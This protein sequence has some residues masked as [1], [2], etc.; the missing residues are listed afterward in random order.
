MGRG[1]WVLWGVRWK[2]INLN[3]KNEY[4]LILKRTMVWG[5]IY[6]LARLKASYCWASYTRRLLWDQICADLLKLFGIPVTLM[7]TE[8][9][10]SQC[11]PRHSPI[12]VEWHIV[13]TTYCLSILIQIVSTMYQNI[14]FDNYH[15]C[16]NG[17]LSL[18]IFRLLVGQNDWPRSIFARVINYGDIIH[19]P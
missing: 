12:K 15:C 1:S 13:M 18:L 9:H 11:W 5:H 19:F 8:L 14:H 17:L 2:I 3:I 10:C 7:W 16:K 6:G 4:Y